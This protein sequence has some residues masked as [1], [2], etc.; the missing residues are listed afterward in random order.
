MKQET[1]YW[2]IVFSLLLGGCSAWDKA[3]EQAGSASF[4]V[5]SITGPAALGFVKAMEPSIDPQVRLG[6]TVQY[7]F[8]EDEE[9][10]YAQLLEGKADMAVVPTEM[11]AKLYHEG[12]GY[13]LAAVN[14]GGYLYLL[15]ADESDQR[16]F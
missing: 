8:E 9:A 15:S 6:D 3:Y 16:S 10:I 12:A 13:Q 1:N 11:A 4:T 7:S 14:T 5:A 2:I